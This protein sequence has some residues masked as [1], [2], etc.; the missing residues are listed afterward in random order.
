MVYVI[1]A[2]GTMDLGWK[3]VKEPV[4]HVGIPGNDAG[5]ALELVRLLDPATSVG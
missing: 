1:Q 3:H 2:G 4:R 5:L